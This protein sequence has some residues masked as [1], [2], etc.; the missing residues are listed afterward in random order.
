L[1]PEALKMALNG[2]YRDRGMRK[3]KP[4]ASIPEQHIG[5]KRVFNQ[6][7]MVEKPLIS[8]EQAENINHLLNE[9]LHYEKPVYITYYTR[10]KCVAERVLI[11]QVDTIQNLLFFVEQEQQHKKYIS[12]NNL[13]DISFR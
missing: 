10:G 7:D 5:L 3:W 8:S 1:N 12:L 9:A 13:L 2:K 11:K 6:L 4:F